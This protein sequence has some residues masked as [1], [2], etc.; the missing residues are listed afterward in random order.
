[1]ALMHKVAL[2]TTS[3]F[4]SHDQMGGVL[5]NRPIDGTLTNELTGNTTISMEN[6]PANELTWNTRMLSP[7]PSL[8]SNVESG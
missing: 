8:N 7:V 1:M 5:E 2:T 4:F 3:N 6:A